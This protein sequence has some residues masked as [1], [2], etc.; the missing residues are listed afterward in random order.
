MKIAIV[1]IAGQM[2]Q[3]F[4]SYLIQNNHEVNGYDINLHDLPKLSEKL[5]FES[6]NTLQKAVKNR[7]KI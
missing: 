3:W 4:A 7:K 2:G 1:G 6:N 5:R